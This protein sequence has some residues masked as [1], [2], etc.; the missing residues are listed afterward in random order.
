MGPEL[1]L[2]RKCNSGNESNET[3]SSSSGSGRMERIR[4]EKVPRQRVQKIWRNVRWAQ[5]FPDETET[6]ESGDLTPNFALRKIALLFETKKYDE[7]A[8]L[9]RRLNCV[10]LNNI[11]TEVP[12]DVLLDTMPMSLGVLES[13][14]VKIYDTNPDPFPKE[15][16]CMDMLLKRMVAC[17]AKLSQPGN[18]MEKN[19][20]K[21]YPSCRNILRI[22]LLVE[23]NVRSIIKEKKKA[24]D[25]C[26]KHLGQHGLVD[27]SGGSLMNLHDALKLEF[28]KTVSQYRSALQKLDEMSLSTKHPHSSSVTFGKAPTE[29][30]HQRLMQMARAEVQSRIIKNKT[31]YNIVEPALT[32]QY[33]KK[34]IHVLEK[35]IDFDK[36]A[37][38][39]DTELRKFSSDDVSDDAY[40][41]VV[42]RQFSQG[43][44][45]VLQL[46]K[47]VTDHEEGPSEDEDG[48][49]VSSDEDIT[50]PLT[51]TERLKSFTGL[52][53]IVSYKGNGIRPSLIS[54]PFPCQP[55]KFR[56]G[57]V[58][59]HSNRPVIVSHSL[60][61]RSLPLT[62]GNHQPTTSMEQLEEEL[63]SLRSE[64]QRSKEEIRK[65]KERE[66]D[67]LKRLSDQ[68]KVRFNGNH[69]G[70]FEDISHDAPRTS[71]HVRQ[72]G[73]LYT[74]SRME[75]LDSLDKMPQFGELSVLKEKILFSVVVLSFRA[76]QQAVHE[77][78]GK[79]RHILNL[80]HPDV[81][82]SAS[83]VIS[84]H[85]EQHVTDYLRRSADRFD[86]SQTVKEVCSQLYATLYDYPVLKECNG[87][88]KYVENCVK[89]AW[90]LSVQSPPFLI[91]YDSR[92]FHS[93][94]H[95]RFHTS[96]AGSD[97]IKNFLWPSLTEGYGG[98]CV[99]K[100]V[101][102]T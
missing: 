4:P 1:P 27:T 72:F 11:L 63:S 99:F 81:R 2:D 6:M 57:T 80:P 35:R 89:I 13:I 71:D 91:M 34:L 101:V 44:T 20:N 56:S 16:L 77:L 25:K 51:N 59:G 73:N 65:M 31:L 83:D 87:L 21:Y 95:T 88:Q 85:M 74:E 39:H 42:L 98:P 15:Q 69:S 46:L 26:L 54:G 28:E 70:H 30:S 76:T 19:C 8:T 55:Q 61:P 96:D 68:T 82:S 23:P 100:G 3:E 36:V 18:R 7:C 49:L 97:D 50:S 33:L 43:Y 53:G 92:R 78:R 22:I 17:F 90:G 32:N 64:L 10:T 12:I 93:D 9:I 94:L 40:L 86:V 60:T 38:F 102:V 37:L 84:Q 58:N 24:L 48:G 62:N 41:S 66:Q 45:I 29:A 75:A 67:L 14:Y 79:V 47:E 5:S 52:N